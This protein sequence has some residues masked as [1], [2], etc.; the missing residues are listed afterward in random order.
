MPR[1]SIPFPPSAPD[2]T[3]TASAPKAAAQGVPAG[4]GDAPGASGSSLPSPC[5]GTTHMSLE[6]PFWKLQ[7]PGYMV[8]AEKQPRGS[9][10]HVHLLQPHQ[11]EPSLAN[12]TLLVSVS[13]LCYTIYSIRHLCYTIYSIKHTCYTIHSI[14]HLHY[15]IYSIR[16]TH[17]LIF[18]Y[19][20]D[21][22]I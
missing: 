9:R 10:G 19:H 1:A 5:G 17:A 16:H 22:S 6:K 2:M 12:S 8:T 3:G 13:P 18:P 20:S 15:T 14:R 21:S 7:L 4:W 11:E